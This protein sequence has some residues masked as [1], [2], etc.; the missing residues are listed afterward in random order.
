MKTQVYD[1]RIFTHCVFILTVNDR[2]YVFHFRPKPNIWLEKHLALGQIPKPKPKVQIYK[3]TGD[4]LQFNVSNVIF[5][6]SESVS[7]ADFRGKLNWT[8][9]FYQ[10]FCSFLALYRFGAI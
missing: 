10:I 2:K 6:Q 4:L 9:T 7:A 8:S 5:Q 3:N 1:Y